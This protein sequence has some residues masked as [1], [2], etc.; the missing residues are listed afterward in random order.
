MASKIAVNKPGSFFLLT[1][2]EAVA[3]G[4]LEAGVK[5]AASYPGTPSTEI[6]ETLAEAAKAF[7]VY[8]EWSI[9]EIVAMEVEPCFHETCW[10]EC[11]C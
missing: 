10:I 1:G 11:G 8:V 6:M 2:D 4:A 7:G 9:N 5:V 3:R